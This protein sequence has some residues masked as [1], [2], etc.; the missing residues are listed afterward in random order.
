MKEHKVKIRL[1][2]DSSHA[3][4]SV[5]GAQKRLGE[6]G[7]ETKKLQKEFDRGDK[8][9]EEFTKSIDKLDKEAAELRKGLKAAGAS[10]K[11]L[12]SQ[13]SAVA[14]SIKADALKIGVA[15]AA[16]TLAM[17]AAG[18]AVKESLD[19]AAQEAVLR[20]QLAAVGRSFDDFIS[21][22]QSAAHET[23]SMQQ[24]ISNAT[25]GRL[26]G[27]GFD[28]MIKLLEIA[29]VSAIATGS[30]VSKAFDDITLGIAR[31][32]RMILD[33]Q[34][35]IINMQKAHEKL[36]SKLGKTVE[37][38]TKAERS[39]SLLNQVLEQG[40]ERVVEFGDA[41]SGL[42]ERLEQT[43][44]Q[45]S[46]FRQAVNKL[47]SEGMQ[48]WVDVMGD[49]AHG[50]EDASKGLDAYRG[51]GAEVVISQYALERAATAAGVSVAE[52]V[53]QLK[54]AKEELGALNTEEKEAADVIEVHRGNLA[55][56][57]H[58]LAT[59][60]PLYDDTGEAISAATE[61]YNS[62]AEAQERE[63]RIQRE[64]ADGAEEFSDALK[65]LGIRLSSDINAE[66]EKN[67]DLLEEN[68]RRLSLGG[69]EY[70]DFL[71]TQMDLTKANAEL[72]KELEG[73]GKEIE[74]TG[75]AAGK[76]ATA[77]DG[78]TTSTDAGVDAAGKLRD[79]FREA[80]KEIDNAGRSAV[81]TAREFDKMAESAGRAAAV[82]AGIEGGGTLV[83]GGTRIRFRGGSRLT[84]SPGIGGRMFNPEVRSYVR[85]D[86]TVVFV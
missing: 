52:Y 58:L 63:L 78:L 57:T 48:R 20:K 38:L 24:I 39:T 1:E 32:S 6:L 79:G 28:D 74:G 19:I 65:E 55:S 4:Q 36:A 76:T 75:T 86:G 8:S 11:S 82:A 85:P 34:G 42:K 7:K 18:R 25:R 29:R 50:Y 2:G 64:L 44:A 66:I 45:V 70:R 77:V 16:V 15:I 71:Q 5:K 31:E 46:D 69:I 10:T 12:G 37:Q 22:A 27:L 60:P 61:A 26:L 35:F 54:K 73:V 80:K 47:L 17:R 21:K 43:E 68:R 53:K 56:L 59:L 9:A 33:N 41:A 72:H 83:Q 13:F 3:E 40:A 51:A 23:L 62:L 14:K 67:N 84:S 30:T 81:T 49:L